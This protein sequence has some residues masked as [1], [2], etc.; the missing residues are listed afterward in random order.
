MLNTHT[1]RCPICN[2]KLE[3]TREVAFSGTTIY[4]H[5]GQFLP[6]AEGSL[7][8]DGSCDLRV[9]CEQGHSIDEMT[10]HQEVAWAQ[11]T[12]I[13]EPIYVRWSGRTEQLEI[14]MIRSA[15][16]Q[17]DIRR[18]L[19]SDDARIVGLLPIYIDSDRVRDLLCAA[20]EAPRAWGHQVE[21]LDDPT[22]G[23]GS[24]PTEVSDYTPANWHV[25]N[26]TKG[27]SITIIDGEDDEAWVLDGHAIAKGLRL[28]ADLEPMHFRHWRE[29]NEDAITG[30]IF[31]QLA[32]LGEVTY[33]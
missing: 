32:V 30:D 20:L 9:W 3:A 10:K 22:Q 28:L 5:N 33:G 8:D 31:L 14:A 7:V 26:P 24:T 1:D 19:R 27:G 4:W 16:D 29:E 17:R 12:S 18:H 23:S 15:L 25:W 2:G 6:D 21:R 11:F 13:G